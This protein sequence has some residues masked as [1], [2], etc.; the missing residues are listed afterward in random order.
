MA[1]HVRE[2]ARAAGAPVGAVLE[3]GYQPQA[4]A[5][6]VLAT[7]AALNGVGEAEST[8]PDRIVTSRLGAHV[9]H[10]WML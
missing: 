8:A 2:L 3:G 5:D 4:L 7:I 10:F 6:C 9:G 1:C